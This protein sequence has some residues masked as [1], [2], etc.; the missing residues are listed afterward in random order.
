MDK[1]FS[2]RAGKEVDS[3]LK[4]SIDCKLTRQK[5]I[6]KD[7]FFMYAKK[8]R[9]CEIRNNWCDIL[10]LSLGEMHLQRE[11]KWVKRVWFSGAGLLPLAGKP[12]R[13][14]EHPRVRMGPQEPGVHRELWKKL[15]ERGQHTDSDESW[16]NS[17]KPGTLPRKECWTQ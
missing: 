7:L 4:S 2:H 15:E 13:H 10:L 17:W 11:E 9:F 3:E 12:R 1:W 5:Q 6:K 8:I 16:E 14:T